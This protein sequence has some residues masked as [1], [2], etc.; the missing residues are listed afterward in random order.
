MIGKFGTGALAAL[1]PKAGDPDRG[2][3]DGGLS[4]QSLF[5]RR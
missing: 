4:R 5:R 1:T 2:R 3:G